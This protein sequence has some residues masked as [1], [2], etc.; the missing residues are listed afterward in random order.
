M[1]E[2]RESKRDLRPLRA[3]WPFLKPYPGVLILALVALMVAAGATLI[4]PIAVRNMI[5]LGFSKEDAAFVDQY[6]LGLLAVVAILALASAARFYFVSWIGER[7]AADIRKQVYQHVLGLSPSFF[8]RTPTGEILSRLTTD[9]TLIQTI[10]GAGASMALRN[11]F[12]F[13]GGFVM[14]TLTSPRL[15]GLTVV[16]GPIVLAAIIL[17]G[18]RVRRMS[19]ASQDRV[20]ATSA[21]ASETLDAVQTIQAFT[22]ENI[23]GQRF[24]R[25][26]ESAFTA[27][28]QRIKARAVLTAAVIFLV[29]GAVVG[30]LWLGAQAVLQER[31]S[32]GELVQFLLY[33]VIVAS[34]VGGLSEVWGEIQRVAGATERL[35]ELLE[36]HPMIS[37]PVRPTPLPVNTGGTVVEFRNVTF[38]YPTERNHHPAL[39]DFTLKIRAGET[40]ALVGPSGAGKSTVF[41]LLLRF[42]DPQSGELLMDGINLAAADPQ[43]IRA[44][45]GLVPQD[46]VLFTSDAMENIRYG[47]PEATDEEVIAASRA[48]F[49]DEFIREQA[50]GYRTFLGER[51]IKLSG[52]QRQRIAIARAILKDPSVML[53]DEATSSL[54]AESER[55]VHEALERLMANRTTL[56]I[57]HRLATVLKAD[58]IIVMDKGYIVATGRHDELIQEDGLYAHLAALQLRPPDRTE[59]EGSD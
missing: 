53:L 40:V 20:A 4:F 45:I 37:A 46:T 3:L 22:H 51:G 2:P 15:M 5:D 14:L 31:M 13:L 7:V 27:A 48:A 30:V 54:D 49:A 25:A 9:T 59:K 6:F 34:S 21:M 24:S 35:M 29:F 57:A 39:D 17:G 36:T 42:Y 16:V 12:L 44:R 56:I 19:R 38:V 18:R 33:A 58:R 28:L 32:G 41:K 26:V 23:E 52:G 43:S 11:L 1:S 8:E 55:L 50:D 47:R 10:I